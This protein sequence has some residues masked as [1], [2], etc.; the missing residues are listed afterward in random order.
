VSDFDRG[1]QYLQVVN[2]AQLAQHVLVLRD[3]LV[4]RR[5]VAGGHEVCEQG[6]QG[7]IL[8]FEIALQALELLRRVALV[9]KELFGFRPIVATH[10]ETGRQE[11]R[12]KSTAP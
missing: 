4:E 11:G 9:S 1:S 10:G 8:A 6:H 12:S 3:G 5:V 7:R 2:L